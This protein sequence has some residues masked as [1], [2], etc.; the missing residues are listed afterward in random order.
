MNRRPI[1]SRTVARKSGPIS[2]LAAGMMCLGLSACASMRAKDRFDAMEE[3][4]R[5]QPVHL[6]TPADF[7]SSETGA[8][9]PAVVTGPAE[10]GEAAATPGMD[11]GG[12]AGL[13]QAAQGTEQGSSDVPAAW[14]ASGLVGQVNGRPI[15]VEEFFAPI[16]SQLDI[17]SSEKPRREFLQEADSIVTDRLISLV[18]NEL[19]LAEARAKLTT[20]QRQG[21]LAWLERQRGEIMRRKGGG[22][23]FL[24]NE[25]LEEE[26]GI[27]LKQQMELLERQALVAQELRTQVDEK[28]VVDW[29]DVKRYYEEHEEEFHPDPSITLRLILTPAADKS[30]IA[31]VNRELE[32]GRPFE[33]VARRHSTLYAARGGL[34]ST[35]DLPNGLGN[36]PLTRW[37]EIDAKARTLAVGAHSE[38]VIVGTDVIW[39]HVE[40]YSDGNPRSLYEAQKDI[41]D[42]LFR[43]ARNS[44]QIGYFQKLLARGN[45]DSL[46]EMKTALMVVVADRWLKE[47]N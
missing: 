8:G 21:L 24:T 19:I 20:E 2:Y 18:Q 46:E 41:E 15:Y 5:T 9:Q 45:A 23:E 4:E 17:A 43:A 7:V 36:T 28:I 29:R 39:V 6:V 34:M 22:V 35:I 30:L 40:Q 42:K 12:S 27:T 14:I 26:S 16:A 25:R 38:E 31:T 32:E 47:P 37:P 13:A 33:D 3:E 10:G 44:G 1:L 11:E